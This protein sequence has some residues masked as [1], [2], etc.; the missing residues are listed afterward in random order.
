VATSYLAT[1][2]SP[3]L[4]RTPDGFLLCKDVLVARSGTLEYM[5]SELGVPGTGPITVHR[6]PEEI[7]NPRFL[8]SCEGAVVCDSHP[9][10]FVDP[11]NYQAFARG[12]AQNSRVGP[13][14]AHGNTQVL[15]DLFINDSGLA[16]K[17]E[18]GIVRDVSIGFDLELVQDERGRWTQQNLRVNHIAVVAKGRGITTKILDAAPQFGLADLAALYLG[19]DPSAVI[20]PSHSTRAMDSAREEA[21]M[22]NKWKCSE[23]GN[24]NHPEAE[25]CAKCG[26]AYDAEEEELIPQPE[27]RRTER[28]ESR[29]EALR[30]LRRIRPRIER[31]G[32]DAEKRLWNA[33]FKAAR[34]GRVSTQASDDAPDREALRAADFVT[35]ATS[36]LGK[37]IDDHA[38]EST[39]ARRAAADAHPEERTV[40]EDLMLKAEQ[41]RQRMCRQYY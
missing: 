19:R 22:E 6:P 28:K 2:I 11:G 7:T 12:H 10:R 25:D 38:S 37:A 4:A 35:V 23:C 27:E 13:R 5:P 40:G 31:E 3:H 8:A 36:Y 32:T 17:V 24:V 9:G 18:A 30:S 16:D 39:I 15:C 1:R 14:D 33:A 29:D 21:A 20:V 26:R 34:D 41:M